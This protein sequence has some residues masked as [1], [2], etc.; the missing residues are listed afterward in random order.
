MA[1]SVDPMSPVELPVYHPDGLSKKGRQEGACDSKDDGNDH[2]ARV[3]PRH[4]EFR[5]RSGDQ[6]D[7]QG[8]N[9]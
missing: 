2:A 9:E 5:Q 8:P 6:T 4:D 3:L 7:D 1:P